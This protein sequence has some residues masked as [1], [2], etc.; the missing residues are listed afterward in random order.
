VTVEPTALRA[1]RQSRRVLP[2]GA[3][4][5]DFNHGDADPG[6]CRPSLSCGAYRTSYPDGIAT[7]DEAEL[8]GT[9]FARRVE[10]SLRRA[11]ALCHESR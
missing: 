9:I 4:G 8:A 3:A 5:R 7:V 1:T 6:Y 10:G 2:V 11:E